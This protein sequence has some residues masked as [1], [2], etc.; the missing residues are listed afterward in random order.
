MECSYGTCNRPRRYITGEYCSAHE[1]RKRAGRDMDKPLR[2]VAPRADLP[3]ECTLDDCNRPYSAKGL[4]RFHYGRRYQGRDLTSPRQY[5]D[6]VPGVSTR[7]IGKGYVYVWLPDHPSKPASGYIPQHR[8]VMEQHL[9]RTLLAAESVHHKNGCKDDN[10][11]ENLELWASLH[12]S[13][14]RVEDLAEHARMVL[15][16]YGNPEEKAR[17]AMIDSPEQVLSPEKRGRKVS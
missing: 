13:G 16:L 10:R 17:Y 2:E 15:A 1:Q 4:C 7:V 5:E 9:G 6:R 11:I 14:Q 3:D 12:P 8:Y